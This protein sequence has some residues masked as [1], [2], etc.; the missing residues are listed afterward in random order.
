M[1]SPDPQVRDFLAVRANQNPLK[2]ISDKR[3]KRACTEPCWPREQYQSA[4]ILAWGKAGYPS[5]SGFL[6]LDTD[7]SV[8]ENVNLSALLHEAAI[9]MNLPRAADPLVAPFGSAGARIG[10]VLERCLVDIEENTYNSANNICALPEILLNCRF[11][12]KNSLIW[13]ADLHQ[14]L[15]QTPRSRQDHHFYERSEDLR[16]FNRT[17]I[18]HSKLRT[19]LICGTYARS[20]CLIHW[21]IQCR[22]AS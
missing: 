1:H 17:L 14:T 19:I 8:V 6:K 18:G 2:A 11:T 22:V 16:N 15:P 4:V 7:T 20:V 3:P 21:T 9:S 13:T 10:V 5:T 12:E